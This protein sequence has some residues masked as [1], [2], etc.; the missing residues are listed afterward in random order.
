MGRPGT[1]HAKLLSDNGNIGLGNFTVDALSLRPSLR[2]LHLTRG[3]KKVFI[4]DIDTPAPQN[5]LLVDV[6]TNIPASVIM[7]DIFIPGGATSAAAIVQ[8]GDVGSGVIYLAADGFDE[9][10]IP[11]EVVGDETT[12]QTDRE[13]FEEIVTLD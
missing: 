11:I 9:L 13:D 3:E 4:V 12:V 10:Q 5:G 2:N 6:T 8:G 1:Y 7:R